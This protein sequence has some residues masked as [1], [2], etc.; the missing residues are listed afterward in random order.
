[1][2]YITAHFRFFAFPFIAGLLLYVL[3]V[4]PPPAS[5]DP[6]LLKEI[7]ISFNQ[8]LHAESLA[9]GSYRGE[10]GI[11]RISPEAAKIIGMN[12][13]IDQDYLE[14]RESRQNADRS[15]D[16]AKAALVLQKRDLTAEEQA[17]QIVEH[18][19]SFKKGHETAREKLLR[20]R[21]KLNATADER[22]NDALALQVMD[23]FLTE[24]LKRMDYRLR[25]ALAYFYNLCHGMNQ[26]DYALTTENVGFVNEVFRQFVPRAS[27]ES[28]R[29]F[30]LDKASGVNGKRDQGDWKKI[31]ERYNS[32]YASVLEAT[33]EKYTGS[34]N[35]VDPL[36][37]IALMRRESGFDASAL[38]RVGAAGLTQIMPQTA[39]E[40]GMKNIFK[41]AYF[42][43]ALTLMEQERRTRSEAMSALF[44]IT[45]ENGLQSAVRARE[46]MQ[47]SLAYGQEKDRLFAQYRVDLARNRGDDRFKPA[48]A[49]EA[50]FRYFSRLLKEHEG[51]VSLALASYNAGSHRV[52]EYGGIPPFSET[53]LFRNKVLEYYRDYM[54]KAGENH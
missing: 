33:A 22:L 48:Q 45:E 21:S 3:L 13:L 50:G 31:I 23:R 27:K 8:K 30:D 47:E 37:F 34:S 19:L 43:R 46:L 36:L 5:A 24:S 6:A 25:D 20:Y 15:L 2:A 7:L 42:D 40:L 9:D 35:G 51:D 18:F 54:K 11:L 53:V 32:Q 39:L 44:K 28:L 26:P 10:E 12:A 17:Q 29:V 38:S 4:S 41:P 52:R 14:A 49:I 1:M 16:R